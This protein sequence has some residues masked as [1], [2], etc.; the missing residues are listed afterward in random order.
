MFVGS[1]P[2]SLDTGVHGERR[3]A[4]VQIRVGSAGGSIPGD[5]ANFKKC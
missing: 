4:K 3:T 5:L 1:N 2:D